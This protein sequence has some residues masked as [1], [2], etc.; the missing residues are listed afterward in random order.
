MLALTSRASSY[1]SLRSFF[2][3]APQR[4]KWA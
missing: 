2:S 4:D 3:C 1:L